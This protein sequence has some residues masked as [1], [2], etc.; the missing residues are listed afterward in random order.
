MAAKS[1]AKQQEAEATELQ[2]PSVATLGETAFVPSAAGQALAELLVTRLANLHG[3][4]LLTDATACGAAV[5]AAFDQL[6]KADDGQ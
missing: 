4:Q 1:E 3:A 6:E 2:S 5:K